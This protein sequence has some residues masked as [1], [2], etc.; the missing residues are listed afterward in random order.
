MHAEILAIGS[1]VISGQLLDTNTQWLSRHLEELGIRVLYHSSVGDESGPL[2][3]AFRHAIDRADLIIS[4]GGLGPTAD[5]LTREALA[6]AV[7]QPLV[8]N[9]QALGQIREMFARRK[10]EMPPQNQ[11]QALFPAGSRVVHNPHGTAP[12][13]ELDVPRPAAAPA[14]VI[15]LP[16]V[17]AEM[18]DMWHDSVAASLRQF[19]AGQRI[20]RHKQIKCFG[21]GESH[22][23]ALLPEGFFQQQSPRVGINVS[24]TTIILRIAAE[25][26]DEQ[27]CYAVME[28]VIATIH[29][30]LGSLVFGED[31]EELQHAVVRLLRQRQKTV[32]V[33]EWGT[34]GLI[35]QWLGDVP[36]AAGCFLGGVTVPNETALKNV[37]AVPSEPLG[38]HEDQAATAPS[39]LV[40]AMAAGCRERFGADYALA[41]G[42][43]PGFDPAAAQ[44]KP[45]CFALAGPTAVKVKQIPFAGHPA[46][47]KVFC[48]KYAL[49][50]LRLTLMEP[51]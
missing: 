50:L 51:S 30:C 32:A 49:N 5:D 44:P 45:V 16:G 14:R 17:P 4:T 43:F 8:L 1:E 2:T 40:Q 25:G 13:I 41:V 21:V 3:E 22:L 19:G 28:P 35:T 18:R 36:A 33:A 37:L 12:G 47:L 42:P 27:E 34:A 11:R 6:Q 24:Q 39:E 9:E 20:I 23:E 48:A 38:S 15:A 10:R 26:A 31:D 29:R 7:G 46:T